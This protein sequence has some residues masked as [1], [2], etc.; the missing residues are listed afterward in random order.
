[1]ENNSPIS[2]IH[3]A[4][5]MDGNGRWAEA[6]G[7]LRTEGHKV[8]VKVVREIVEA[9]V[10]RGVGYLTLFAFLQKTGNVANKKLNFLFSLF[11]DA[12]TEYIS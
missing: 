12:V 8:G 3:V 9:S 6:R 7:L 10:E 11:T 2:S 4:I 1:M 5:I